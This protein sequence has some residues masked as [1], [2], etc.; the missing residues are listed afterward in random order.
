MNVPSRTGTAPFSPVH[1]R[2]SRSPR[3]SFTGSVSSPTKAGRI[4]KASSAP[5]ARPMLQALPI[6][7]SRSRTVRPSMMN[8]TISARLASDEWN[9]WISR[10]YGA[11]SSPIRMPAANTARNPDP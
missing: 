6:G 1:N 3:F 7:S 10:L 5:S 4:T 8:A 2:N 11:R 9:R